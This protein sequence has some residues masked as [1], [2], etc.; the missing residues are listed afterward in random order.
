M[1]KIAASSKF[2][3]VIICIVAKKM[4]TS[5]SDSQSNF[6]TIAKFIVRYL[7]EFLNRFQHM[8]DLDPTRKILRYNSWQV[9]QWWSAKANWHTWDRDLDAWN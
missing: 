7:D 8:L 9:E 5:R 4:G 1:N 6:L 2:L 3:K